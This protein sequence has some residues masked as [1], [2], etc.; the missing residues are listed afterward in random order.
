[1]KISERIALALLALG[2]VSTA[3][4][5]PAPVAV[6]EPQDVVP[7]VW[8]IAGSVRSDRQPDGN[9]VVFDAPAGLVVVDT[10]RHAWHREAIDA[11][12]RSQ[13]KKISAIVNTHWHLDHVSGNPALRAAHP[14]SRVYASGAIDG[15]LAGFLTQ[16]AKESAAYL[17]DPQIPETIRE[18]IRADVR[19]IENGLALKPDVV[20]ERSG[21]LDLGGRKMQVHLVPDAVTAGDLWLYDETSRVAILGDLVTLPAPFLD[22]ACPDGWQTALKQVAAVPFEV[23]IPGHGAP[24]SR[25]EFERYRGAF[26]GFIDC[27]RST[28]T[29]GECA[30]R[31]ADAVQPLLAEDP[32]E[33]Q[34]A[35][36]MAEYYVDLLR[37]NGG[38]SRYCETAPE[39][40]RPD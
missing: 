25:R 18:D 26:A 36:G 33:R 31:W 23:V 13:Q 11:L 1:M 7:G 30:T 28:E 40:M 9:S 5:V 14:G 16:S 27:V 21:V 3:W 12:A 4:A 19:S 10:G 22:T 37:A 32:L 17:D 2:T 15:A 38:R 20:V 8:L 29:M 35:R 39:G 6:P 24:M 34:R